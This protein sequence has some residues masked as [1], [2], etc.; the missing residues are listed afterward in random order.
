MSGPR[1][2]SVSRAAL[3]SLG[4]PDYTRSSVV[5]FVVDDGE[6][7]AGVIRGLLR[8]HV[9]DVTEEAIKAAIAEHPVSKAVRKP[10]LMTKEPPSRERLI[11]IVLAE[12]TEIVSADGRV[13]ARPNILEIGCRFVRTDPRLGYENP[14]EAAQIFAGFVADAILKELDL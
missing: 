4:A 5:E 13:I 11:E 6:T 3:V 8:A 7:E 10:P 9:A 2:S 1:I 14:A 12:T